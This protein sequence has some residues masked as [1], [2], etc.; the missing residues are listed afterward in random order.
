MWAENISFG[1][2]NASYG[3]VAA[4]VQWLL[5]LSH[6]FVITDPEVQDYF[7]NPLAAKLPLNWMESF[8]WVPK[9][10]S[11]WKWIPRHLH[12]SC[13]LA[14]LVTED[15]PPSPLPLNHA[16]LF[17]GFPKEFSSVLF[18]VDVHSQFKHHKLSDNILTRNK[19]LAP[20]QGTVLHISL[21]WWKRIQLENRRLSSKARKL[22][23]N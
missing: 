1:H 16:T 4:I 15:R 22:Y 8:N 14:A 2:W 6:L 3:I 18:C 7:L 12:T 20:F 21:V 13:V 10:F 11:A 9:H 23:W 17:P 19:L 5:T